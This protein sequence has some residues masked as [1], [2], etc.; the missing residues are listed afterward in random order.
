MI[1]E[2]TLRRSRNYRLYKIRTAPLSE[3]SSIEN[4]YFKIIA[5]VQKNEKHL[6]KPEHIPANFTVLF[7]LLNIIIII[8]Y[9][10]IEIK[11]NFGN[12]KVYQLFIENGPEKLCGWGGFEQ[13]HTFLAPFSINN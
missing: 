11:E 4:Y 10:T 3:R 9:C 2:Y 13:K 7:N 12:H 1:A 8:V 5:G 6:P